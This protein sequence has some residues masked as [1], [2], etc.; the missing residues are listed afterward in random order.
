MDNEKNKSI[1]VPKAKNPTDVSEQFSVL[2][3]IVQL[4]RI[5]CPWDRKQTNESIA[6]LLIEE[7]YEVL[8]AIENKDDD[9]FQKELGDILL[10]IIMHSIMASER[11]AFN[12][13]NVIA[14]IQ[15]KLVFRHPHVFGNVSVDGEEDVVRN[16]E[17]LKKEEGRQ[18]T[19]DGVPLNLP[20]LLRAERIQ[21]KASRVGFDWEKKEQVWEKVIE[22]LNEL[23][24]ATETQDHE[25]IQEE[26]GDL[27]FAVVNYSRFLDISPETALQ[28]TNNKF[29]KR[30]QAIESYAKENN[31]QLSE[32]TLAEMD[33][34]WNLTKTQEKK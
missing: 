7:A 17:E 18:S 5:H 2:V 24:Q 13:L 15:D 10:H 3:E 28:K 31:K 21:H 23:Q 6:H 8:S 19:L 20:A 4:L 9:E 1:P 11:G 32:L 22:E 29:I 27:L 33:A 30:F 34:I 12:L 16:W 14:S 25:K 26:L